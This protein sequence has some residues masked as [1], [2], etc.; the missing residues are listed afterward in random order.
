MH[1]STTAH[2]L[3]IPL[4]SRGASPTTAFVALAGLATGR[5][6]APRARR[7]RRVVHRRRVVPHRR[8]GGLVDDEHGAAGRAGASRG[9]ASL[10]PLK[11]Y[12]TRV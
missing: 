2:V 7:S 4:L 9:S 6:Y 8:E 12:S 3:D 5:G 1:L 10:K 11:T